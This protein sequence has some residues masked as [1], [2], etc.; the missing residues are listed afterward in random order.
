MILDDGGDA[1][2]LLHLGVRAE[3]DIAVLDKPGSEEEI[4]LFNAIKGR[5]AVDPQ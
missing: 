4:C 5:L 3:K 1:T 2:L